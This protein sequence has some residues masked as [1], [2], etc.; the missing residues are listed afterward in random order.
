MMLNLVGIFQWPIIIAIIHSCGW[1]AFCCPRYEK[2]NP[3]WYFSTL[4]SYNYVSP[5]EITYTPA[6]SLTNLLKKRQ[7]GVSEDLRIRTLRATAG[8]P[9]QLFMVIK[10]GATH[11]TWYGHKLTH[12]ERYQMNEKLG[13]SRK[14]EMCSSDIETIKRWEPP[15]RIRQYVE[16]LV[17][18]GHKDIIALAQRVQKAYPNIF[19]KEYNTQNYYALTRREQ[20]CKETGQLA[21]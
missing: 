4:T 21:F 6:E 14:A 2:T 5:K 8:T 20:Y 10:H 11:P 13:I 9:V 12:Y 15:K 18:K 3:E 7:I 17:E 16:G 19:T 1:K